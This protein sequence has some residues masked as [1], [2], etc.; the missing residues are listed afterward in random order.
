MSAKQD[1]IRAIISCWP[2]EIIQSILAK[3]DDVNYGNSGEIRIFENANPLLVLVRENKHPD[4]DKI[5]KLLLE[6]GANPNIQ[7]NQSQKP[8][9][10]RKF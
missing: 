5:V 4:I 6:K 1:L 7:D 9:D 8:I 2:I 10:L 3:I